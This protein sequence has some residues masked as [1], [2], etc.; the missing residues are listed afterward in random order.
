MAFKCK[1][2]AFAPQ[3]RRE[4]VLMPPDHRDWLTAAARRGHRTADAYRVV[5]DA[6][7]RGVMDPE[8]AVLDG[9]LT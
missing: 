9:L 1:I 3:A 7:A 6:V 8:H 5:S 4:R 2:G